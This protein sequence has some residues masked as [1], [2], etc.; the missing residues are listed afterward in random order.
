[1]VLTGCWGKQFYLCIYLH[2]CMGKKL[3]SSETYRSFHSALNRISFHAKLASTP[4][5]EAATVWNNNKMWLHNTTYLLHIT[6]S[7]VKRT[8]AVIVILITPNWSKHFAFSMSASCFRSVA[9]LSF[10]WLYEVRQ[11]F[12]PALLPNLEWCYCRRLF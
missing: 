3:N 9:L 8:Q 10:R 5:L 7:V 6:N 1:M 2:C 11:H 4:V 12:S